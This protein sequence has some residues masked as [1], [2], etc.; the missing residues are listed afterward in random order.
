M[1]LCCKINALGAAVRSYTEAVLAAYRKQ[2]C[3]QAAASGLQCNQH[4]MLHDMP[5]DLSACASSYINA[6]LL[7]VPA[8]CHCLLPS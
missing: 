2:H 7:V 5:S 1:Q 3:M 6:L 8:C 4:G